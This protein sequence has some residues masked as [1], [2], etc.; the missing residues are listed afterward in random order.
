MFAQSQELWHYYVAS[1]VMSFGLSIGSGAAFPAAIM[2]WFEAKRGRA[3]R[4]DERRE[5]GGPGSPAPVLALLVESLGWRSTVMVGAVA[6]FI[7]GMVSA[8]VVR[9]PPPRTSG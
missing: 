8:F 7:A 1:L 6:I 3:T 2:K 5:R 4:R 9:D